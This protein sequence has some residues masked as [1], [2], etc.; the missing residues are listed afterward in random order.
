MIGQHTNFFRLRPTVGT[1]SRH[2]SSPMVSEN[3]DSRARR[4]IL[5]DLH[6]GPR[7]IVPGKPRIYEHDDITNYNNNESLLTITITLNRSEGSNTL[8]TVALL[9]PG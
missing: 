5:F 9:S 7:T 8:L 1:G 2:L 4:E 3:K 6:D